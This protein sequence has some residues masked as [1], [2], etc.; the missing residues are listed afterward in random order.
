MRT[1]AGASPER[2][3]IDAIIRE[4]M[5]LGDPE[6]AHH[7]QRFF[8]TEPGGYGEGDRFLGLRVPQVRAVA[9]HHAG[10]SLTATIEVL[11]SPWHEA[12][13]L[14]LVLMASAHAKGDADERR[15][16]LEAYL[17]HTDRVNNWDLVDASA[18]HIIGPHLRSG[19][20]ALLT[21]LARSESVW[22]RRIAIIATSYLIRLGS[23]GETLRI[24]RLL[25]EDPHDLIHKSAGWMLREVGKRDRETEERFLREHGPVMPRTMLRYAIERFPPD[26]RRRYLDGH[27]E[28]G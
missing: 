11:R 12:R 28:P 4:L 1:P 20:N 16:I 23:F 26:L 14:A 8:R 6:R 10:L 22:E 17:D 3:R 21:R 25:L 13:L 7:L 19:R 15:A 9:R 27:R 5:I 2:T 18:G 24:A